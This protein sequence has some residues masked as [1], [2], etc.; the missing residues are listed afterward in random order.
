MKR[1][2][3]ALICLLVA[4]GVALPAIIK[5]DELTFGAGNYMIATVL[6]YFCFTAGIVVGI[7]YMKIGG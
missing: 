6:E 5:L 3:I 4:F 2:T 7:I 1:K